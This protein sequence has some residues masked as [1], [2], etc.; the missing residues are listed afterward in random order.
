M[1][2]VAEAGA[3][4]KS[5]V[6][7][8]IL[9]SVR[10]FV[11][12]QLMSMP[13]WLWLFALAIGFANV[14]KAV[15]IDDPVHLLIADAIVKDPLHP[16]RAYVFWG[17]APAPAFELN[18]PHGFFY[19]LAA[20]RVFSTS[21]PA[22]QLV[23]VPFVLLI[24]F[25]FYRIALRLLVTKGRAELATAFLLVSPALLPSINL[26]VDV[27]LLAL[28]LFFLFLLVERRLA[29]AGIA[30]GAA[31][32]VKYTALAFVPLAVLR[33]LPTSSLKPNPRLAL[34][35]SDQIALIAV[36]FLMLVAWSVLNL[37][38]IGAIHMFARTLGSAARPEFG[39]SFAL[40]VARALL[41]FVT[42]GGVMCLTGSLFR[43]AI[44][45]DRREQVVFVA[46]RLFLIGLAALFG[47]ALAQS[48]LRTPF[49]GE[50]VSL[51]LARAIFFVWGYDA[52]VL[53]L[54]GFKLRPLSK[55]GMR[56][57]DSEWLLQMAFV[58]VGVFIVTLSPFVAVRHVLLVTPIAILFAFKKLD[59]KKN[60][61]KLIGAAFAVTM[62]LTIGISLADRTLAGAYRDHV[63]AFTTSL[64]SR[65]GAVYYVGHWGV[66]WY[67]ATDLEPYIPGKTELHS[68]DRLLVA[69]NVDRPSITYDDATR[70]DEES[71]RSLAATTNVFR[72]MGSRLGYYAVWQGLPW[73][74]STK[75]L[76]EIFVLRVR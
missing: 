9:R 22:L 11:S 24:A 53:V 20:V 47:Q 37:Y 44:L 29:L 67:A 38:D 31:L 13:V 60:T 68:G 43:Y 6:R 41:W 64:K 7:G 50:P 25:S 45:T 1:R 51:S 72:T 23:L 2:S 57:L 18:Q 14:G 40:L 19:L 52:M 59:H 30:L 74:V 34:P 63:L 46:V 73:S 3:E 17:D 70:L 16:M 42:C 10:A 5:A 54:D 33:A 28:L 75:Q 65:E 55:V 15:H 58:G 12:C 27:P 36:P 76:D 26:M 39:Q 66:Q 49:S 4:T 62:G 61:R 56:T 48:G 71:V 35:S 32:W 8:G 69:H 21:I